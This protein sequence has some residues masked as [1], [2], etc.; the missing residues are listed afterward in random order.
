MRAESKQIM[1]IWKKSFL[2]M[3]EGKV[4]KSR[5][6]AVLL[7]QEKETRGMERSEQ[8]S[9]SQMRRGPKVK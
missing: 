6:G 5:I 1:G 7:S 9:K 2:D 3:K 8:G 4:Q